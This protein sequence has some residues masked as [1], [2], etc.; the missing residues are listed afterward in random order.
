MTDDTEDKPRGLLLEDVLP[1]PSPELVRALL[2][3][4]AEVERVAA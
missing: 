3:Y 2:G 1:T 4:F